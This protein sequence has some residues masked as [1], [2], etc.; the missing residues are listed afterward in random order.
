VPPLPSQNWPGDELQ[1]PETGTQLA[2][3][4]TLEVV[5]GG[6]SWQLA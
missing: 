2:D 4:S 6:Q 1:P 5:P 3:P